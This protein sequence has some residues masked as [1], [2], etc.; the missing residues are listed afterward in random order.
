MYKDFGL[1]KSPFNIPNSKQHLQECVNAGAVHTW[2]TEGRIV[3]IMK[4][5]CKQTVLGHY[6]TIT[7]FSIDVE[8]VN[9]YILRRND[10]HL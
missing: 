9:K 8:T 2:T 1:K 3:L 7:R 5:K 4:D 10:G 6:R